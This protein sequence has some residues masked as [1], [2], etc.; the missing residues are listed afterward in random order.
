MYSLYIMRGL[1]I[2]LQLAHIGTPPGLA[3]TRFIMWH[4]QHSFGFNLLR[5]AAH[6]ATP[7][8]FLVA[9]AFDLEHPLHTSA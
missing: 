5:Q 8:L 6:T 1:V 2:T 4:T 7:C 9:T 3:A